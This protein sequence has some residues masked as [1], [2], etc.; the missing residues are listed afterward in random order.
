MMLMINNVND[1]LNQVNIKLQNFIQEKHDENDNLDD[2]YCAFSYNSVQRT[3]NEIDSG[4]IDNKPIIHLEED[5]DNTSPFYTDNDLKEETEGSLIK[6]EQM[7]MVYNIFCVI[8]ENFKS[9]RPR[10]HV[11]NEI[12]SQLRYKFNNYSNKLPEFRN[13]RISLS[14]GFLTRDADNLYASQQIL[15]FDVFKSVG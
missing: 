2:V 4:N 3:F 13:I 9:N 7:P 1:F 12:I 14:E 6:V 8:N 5:V 11:L 10:K 15:T